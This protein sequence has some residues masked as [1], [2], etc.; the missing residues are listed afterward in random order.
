MDDIKSLPLAD[1]V[2][3][4]VPWHGR[5]EGSTLYTGKLN[6]IS[7][8]IT[9]SWSQPRDGHC[10]LIQKPGLPDP[11]AET[12]DLKTAHAMDGLEW[13]NWAILSGTGNIHNKSFSPTNDDKHRWIWIDENGEVFSVVFGLVA[14]TQQLLGQTDADGFNARDWS[15]ADNITARFK[16]RRFGDL[17][18]NGPSAATYTLNH[19]MSAADMGQTGPSITAI[20]LG[21]NGPYSITG[22][23]MILRDLSKTGNK[24]IMEIHSRILDTRVMRHGY[25]INHDSGTSIGVA[26]AEVSTPLGFVE[27]TL[28]GTGASPSVSMTVLADRE[29]T[30][31]E[32]SHTRPTYSYESNLVCADCSAGSCAFACGYTEIDASL[33][34]YNDRIIGYGYDGS[35]SPV[36]HLLSRAFR[37]TENTIVTPTE[38]NKGTVEQSYLRETTTRLDI[39]SQSYT[40]EDATEYA[41]S[42]IRDGATCSTDGSR[43]STSSAESEDSNYSLSLSD[44]GNC[45]LILW[46]VSTPESNCGTS[47]GGPRG[48][49]PLPVS[50][51]QRNA[52]LVPVLSAGISVD[53]DECRSGVIKLGSGL[54]GLHR[55]GYDAANQL[56]HAITCVISPSDQT[57]AYHPFFNAARTTRLYGSINPKTNE[58]AWPKTSPVNF[59]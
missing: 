55:T 32:Q 41:Y 31:G 8:E 6:A 56:K 34:E 13:T 20:M 54:Y 16:I 39:G 59:A 52:F 46:D 38:R 51:L 26:H 22:G 11:Y 29:T 14:G 45:N 4:G 36:P 58:L 49:T 12:P 44:F 7:E 18:K 27:F 25:M 35:G 24:I 3:F 10:W 30:L 17:Q 19:S 57:V 5:I 15:F 1:V 9:R 47:C 33:L 43:T 50:S 23:N 42:A 21:T 28:S 40:L 53:V 48:F 37:Y 2:Q